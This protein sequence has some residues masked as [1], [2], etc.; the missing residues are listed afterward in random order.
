MQNVTFRSRALKNHYLKTVVKVAFR[1]DAMLSLYEVEFQALNLRGR[2]L[3]I[4]DSGALKLRR[5][6]FTKACQLAEIT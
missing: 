5:C 1:T 2:H 4:T 6:D 3:G